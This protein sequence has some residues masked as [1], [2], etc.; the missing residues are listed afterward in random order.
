MYGQESVNDYVSLGKT[1]EQAINLFPN[2]AISYYFAGLSSLK[3]NNIKTA[4]EYKSEASLIAGKN[5]AILTKVQ[6]LDSRILFSENKISE[7]LKAVDESIRLSN[8]KWLVPIEWK[9]DV[10]LASGNKA[11]AKM[12]FQKALSMAGVSIVLQE[13]LSKCQ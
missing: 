4:R 12:Q 2:Q 7:A 9:G 13:K 8:E 3:Q 10:L 5:P 11:E 1:A 6:Y